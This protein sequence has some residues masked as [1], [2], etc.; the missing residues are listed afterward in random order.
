MN[1]ENFYQAPPMPTQQHTEL[2]DRP[3]RNFWAWIIPAGTFIIGSVLGGVVGYSIAENFEVEETST[4]YAEAPVT[5]GT[6][7]SCSD[8]LAYAD[9]A[10]AESGDALVTTSEAYTAIYDGDMV[11]YERA[12]DQLEEH[13]EVIEELTPLYHEAKDQCHAGE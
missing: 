11:T 10:L 3:R 13:T 12:S 4:D 6:P 8:A 1:P 7:E 2:P 5:I 9:I